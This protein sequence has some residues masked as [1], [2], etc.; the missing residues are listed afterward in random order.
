MIAII[1][2]A[3]SFTGCITR[4]IKLHEA[5]KMTLASTKNVNLRAKHYLLSTSAGFDESQVKGL[6]RKKTRRKTKKKIIENYEKLKGRNI[7]Q[8]I[9]NVIESVPGGVYIEN[10]EIYYTFKGL[11]KIFYIASGD[12]YGKKGKK[13]RN[14]RGFYVGCRALY[15]NKKEGKVISIIDNQYCL[16]RKDGIRKF[17]FFKLGKHKSKKLLYDDLIKIDQ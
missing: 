5:G 11:K 3:I 1:L 4:K 12:V 10:L 8:A 13:E 14:I 9:N 7:E 17:L 15:K 16:W 2:I 6:E